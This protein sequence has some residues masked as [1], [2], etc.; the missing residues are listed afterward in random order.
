MPLFS[1]L[2]KR[3]PVRPQPRRT[4]E[5]KASPRFW[6]QLELLEG[7]DLPSS[8]YDPASHLI[9]VASAANNGFA[10]F[11][12]QGPGLIN[13]APPAFAGSVA[14]L[15][16]RSG[17]S[18]HALRSSVAEP[19]FTG[20]P[21]HVL[22]GFSLSPAGSLPYGPIPGPLQKL[23]SDGK[24][25]AFSSTLI[26]GPLQ[27]ASPS[28]EGYTPAQLQQAYGFNQI[29]LPAG[30]TFNDAG[31]GQTIA[32]ID[33][34]NDPNIIPDLQTFDKT[35]N[36]GGAANDP[37]STTFFKVVNQ[38]GGS[39][40]PPT[41][42][43]DFG[44]E[45]SLDVEWA[46]AM[47]PGANILLVEANSAFGNDLLTAIEFAA[48]QPGVSVVS[49]S[50]GG[51]EWATEYQMDNA[52]TTPAGHQG[53]SFIASAGDSGGFNTSYPAMSPNV[54]SVGGTTLPPDQNGNPDRS[55]ETG[56]SVGSD[57][58]NPSLGGGGGISTAEAEPAYQL[59][60][61]STGARTGPD[62]A[63]DSDPNTG[64]PVYDTLLS[65][66]FFPGTPWFKIGGTSDA[67]PQI[68]SLVAIT[69]QL[70]VAAKEGTLD[71]P[72]QLL[73]AIYQIAATDPNAFQDI[74]TGNNGY[75][76]GPG[77]D[78]VTG[79]GTPNAQ[80]LVPDL[81]AAY[82]TSA[83]PATLYWT[84]D[85]S[86]NWDT[87]GN[88]STVDP[89][90][91][92]V[93][94]S[95]LPTP[96]DNVVVDLSRATI[97]HDTVNYDTISSFTVTAANVTVDLGS[98]TLDLSGAGG[99]GTFRVDQAGDLVTMEA[100]VLT[101][102]DV[103]AGTT[104]SSSSSSASGGQLVSLTNYGTVDVTGL[105][106]TLT[107]VTNKG[108][109][110]GTSAATV[111]F[112]GSWDNTNGTIS[113]D[114]SS[115]L[116]LGQPLPTSFDLPPTLVDASPYA[117]NQSTVGT[118][119]VANGATIGFGG[120]MTTDT[121][122][123]FPSLPGVSI[124]LSQ[125][126]VLLDGFL[127]N[128]PADNPV[129]GGVLALTSGTGPV[130][131]GQPLSVASFGLISQGTI[132]SSGTG[133]LVGNYGMLDSVTIDGTM[134]VPGNL[135]LEGPVINNGTLIVS[136]QIVQGAPGQLIQLSG[137]SFINNGTLNVTAGLFD[138]GSSF[139]NNGTISLN[140][141]GFL[142][143]S[144]NFPQYLPVT[145][146]NAGTI[147]ETD[148]SELYLQ[149]N[150]T[151]TGTITGA[152]SFILLGGNWDN[153][154]GTISVD[155]SS[156]LLLGLPTFL[157]PNFPPPISDGLPY[158]VNFSQVGT[159][160]VANGAI[161]GL[162][163]LMTTD[164]FHAF[165]TL[166]GVSMNVTQ[167]TVVLTGWLDNTPADNPLS[168][169][170]LA[171]N[172]STGVLYMAGGDIYHGRITTSGSDDL[173]G[174]Y[175]N[176]TSILDGVELDGNMSVTSPNV[177]GEVVVLNSLTLNGTI[178][179]PGGDGVLAFGYFDNA[180]ETI[181]GTGTI[182]LGAS[183]TSFGG[184]Y[185]YSNAGLTI[186]SGITIDAAASFSYI[187]ADGSTIENQGTVE[188][189]TAG[190]AL[191][192]VGLTV[193]GGSYNPFANYSAG[194]LTGG[195]WE[196]GNGA[197]WNIYGFDLTT[198]AANLSVSGA[199]TQILDTAFNHGN[200]SLAGFTTN[201]AGGGFTVGAGYSF[202]APGTFSNAG[203][204]AIQSGAGFSTG[205]S[206]YRQTAGSTTIDGTLT[207]ANVWIN[208]GSL[209]GTGTIVGN[210]TNAGVVTPGD[211]PGT[212]T[213]QGNYTQTAKGALDINLAG[214]GG[215]AQLAV[216]GTATLAGKLNVSLGNGFT[217]PA[218]AWFTIL[219]FATRSGGFSTETGLRLGGGKFFLPSYRPSDVTL[220]V[221]PGVTVVAGT[222]LYIIGGLTSN[223][224]VEIKRIGIS[225]TG[226]TGVQVAAKLNGVST[227][228]TFNQ[229]FSAIYVYA[230]AGNDSVTLADTLTVSANIYAG[231]G[232]DKV[233]AGGGDNTVT[234]GNGNDQVVLGDGSNVV[235]VGNGNDHTSVGDGNN[236]VV[237]GNG[238]DK[239]S[240]GNGDNLIVAGLGHHTVSAGNGSNI[241]IDGSVQLSQSG[242]TLQQVL[243][244]W[245]LH[246]KSYVANIRSRLAVTYNSSHANT[247]DGGRGLDWFWYTYAKDK[248]N[249]KATDLLN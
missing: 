247:L 156:T 226:S 112:F 237:E 174:S 81:V 92:N 64:V 151:N 63:Y 164:Q 224:R 185:D 220:V 4:L 173:V 240:A 6:P 107:N 238:N 100:G 181:S 2:H 48:R 190:S 114:S 153:T 101:R 69:N 12:P 70:R 239:V 1:W 83:A 96:N 127:D 38:N 168:Q 110:K 193:T 108:A 133:V 13:H 169:G 73:P 243:E 182:F 10:L 45:T 68:S 94:Q 33:P 129:T 50:F 19:S 191:Y 99:R 178:D 157:D 71:G 35:F 192:A 3:M 143:V 236:V 80:H 203:V 241:L 242:D 132:T 7:R 176:V 67:A 105:T 152:N 233:T 42:Q 57:A 111:Q 25:P 214:P 167:D 188:D 171:I 154:K 9:T 58:F 160:D 113:V 202:T 11:P 198:N 142:Q 39:T 32:I 249:R 123:A 201:T 8:Y 87:P 161:I 122:T 232:N 31:L 183:G 211:A 150:V 16:A 245:V 180:P 59:G 213:I 24:F 77:Y 162:G 102:A 189:L 140:H 165:P 204:V 29:T 93:Q 118:I 75:A 116:Y 149:A 17:F 30:E 196:V 231:D 56:W 124:D 217:P 76:A 235:T 197:V 177:A 15:A 5:R 222:D 51:G 95:V 49:M 216:S 184:L 166:P 139:S 230:F 186:G 206:D 205:S 46:H 98:G 84:G 60:V 72:N 88:W 22:P 244:D 119:D 91:S 234:L 53:V 125:D 170:V 199:G 163:G 135:F 21:G 90:L 61:Q 155:S 148:F 47:A 146:T 89:L 104:L 246:G 187:E 115:T 106:L 215:N 131:L 145:F 28:G 40:L 138:S 126:T 109:V 78:F 66:A 225:D 227:K 18:G 97:Q 210:V 141:Y 74:T 195:A 219:T 62:L 55:Q 121:F 128:S 212:L 41:D 207:A 228:T 20:S 85:V 229:A 172:A 194:K 144:P 200:N 117:W 175:A 134:P 159:V 223:D 179:M 82:S 79:V 136:S 43:S 37:T 120:L 137:G 27:S 221:G 34:L 54:V 103:T 218:A 23:P 26:L 86:A 65:N 44:V 14:A 158:A 130:N 209:K 248:T 36:I 147:S 52:F 208:A